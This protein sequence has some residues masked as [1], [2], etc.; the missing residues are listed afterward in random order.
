MERGGFKVWGALVVCVALAMAPA[1]QAAP[2][3][4]AADVAAT[5][6]LSRAT[7]TLLNAARPDLPKGLAAVKRYAGQI[8]A[9]CPKAA[10]KSPQNH[11]A[12]QLDNQVVGALTVVG[13][14]TAA[15][16]I[17]AFYHAVKGLRWSNPALT[18]AVKI[19]ATKLQKL[20]AIPVPNLCEDIKEWAA[21]DY[22]TLSASTTQFVQRYEAVDPEAEEGPLI[23]RLARPYASVGDI[24]LF[25]SIETFE[26]ELAETEAH[27][28]FAYKTLMNSI[29]LNQ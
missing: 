2:A 13:Y 4:S 10:A 16:P 22:N 27:A 9:E 19:F 8:A 14:R 7:R 12:E 1:A 20:V 23:M 28:V 11:G 6:A 25:H 18:R 17:G 5:R 15:A 21:S 3:R 24:S 26:S 29:E